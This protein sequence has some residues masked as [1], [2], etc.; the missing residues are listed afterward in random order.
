MAIV[1][2]H[3]VLFRGDTEET[4]RTNLIKN[5]HIETIIG[6]PQNLFYA[7]GIATI[8]MVLRKERKMMMYYLLMHL[9]IM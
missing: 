4:I 2:P 5:N 9:K 3:G 8:I 1:L 7:T 6:L